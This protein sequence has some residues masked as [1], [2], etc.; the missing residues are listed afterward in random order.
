MD[1]VHGVSATCAPRPP[2]QVCI[3]L[4]QQLHYHDAAAV[5]RL[6][7]NGGSWREFLSTP[8][9]AVSDAWW[10]AEW[11]QCAGPRVAQRGQGG[12]RAYVCG[13]QGGGGRRGARRAARALGRA[14]IYLRGLR[15]TGAWRPPQLRLVDYN[16]ALAAICFMLLLGFADDVL[17]VPWR[18]KLVLPCF[19]SLPLL[20]AYSGGTG[21]AAG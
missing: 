16:A 18:V 11:G 4:F 8:A 21:A 5:M 9:E 17:D 1:A 12:G 15:R 20:I 3:V 2:S 7:T 19:A 14:R 13:G 10:V 6:L